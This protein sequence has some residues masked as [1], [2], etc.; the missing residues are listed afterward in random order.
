MDLP[1]QGLFQQMHARSVTGEHLE[2]L[3]K[4]AADRWLSGE[5]RTLTEAVVETVKHAH[6]SPEQVRRVVEFCNTE[7]F[8]RE[9]KKEGSPHR[10]VSFAGGPADPSTVLQDLNDGGGGSVF[11]DGLGDYKSP[12]KEKTSEAHGAE[13][14]FMECFKTAS[15]EYPVENPLGDVVDLREKIARARE[16]VSSE[17]GGLEIAFAD[18]SERLYHQVKLAAMNGAPLGHIASALEAV[19]PDEEFLKVA[20]IQLTPRL[21]H[22]GVFR[23]LEEMNESV[24][25]VASA[26]VVNKSHPM[27]GEFAEYCEALSKLAERRG[28][29]E[30]LTEQLGQLTHF[31]K[32]AAGEAVAPAAAK[33]R[34]ILPTVA[35]A[36]TRGGELAGKAVGPVS[37][38]LLPGS[39]ATA[40]KAAKGLVQIGV[41]LVAANEVR[42]HLK[43]SPTFQGV[44][45]TALSVVP[46]TPQY[47]QRE[48]NIAT[49]Q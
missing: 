11:D 33:A 10:V 8:Q 41:P 27:L 6:L 13:E 19:A 49:G 18:L 38:A 34:G 12:P 1:L 36:L 29:L 14:A 35:A 25:K 16:Q 4:H 23:S 5:H 40:A 45:D 2:V 21:L 48:Y 47:Q 30:I 24:D 7:A 43:Y 22:D 32:C 9:F 44:K 39:G 46:M 42:R 15:V 37:D 17:M 28:A 20:F 3:G 26:R 31:I